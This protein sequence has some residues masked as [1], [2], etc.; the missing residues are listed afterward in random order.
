[1]NDFTQKVMHELLDIMSDVLHLISLPLLESELNVR[2]KS[3]ELAAVR[4]KFNQLKDKIPQPI[5]RPVR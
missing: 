3:A 4:K 2:E 5:Q 1:M